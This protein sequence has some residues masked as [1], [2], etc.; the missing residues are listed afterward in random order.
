MLPIAKKPTPTKPFVAVIGAANMD[1][2]GKMT[3]TAVESDSNPG[4]VTTSSGGVARNIAE[5]LAY[6]GTHCELVTAV[7]A[8]EWGQQL[9]KHC[10][11]L[12]V[13]TSNTL[14]AEAQRTSSYLSMHDKQ[15]ELITAI[16]DMAVLDC[17]N[18]SV[19]A[20]RLETLQMA[21]CWVVDANL[22][23][24]SLAYLFEH[25]ENVPIWVDPVSTIKARR[26]LP[27]RS[28][29]HCITPNLQEAAILAGF[30]HV[31][32]NDAPKLA[33]ALHTSG[34]TQVMIT[35]GDRGA[36]VSDGN[37]AHWLDAKSSMVNNVTGCGDAAMAALVH[38]FVNGA[39]WLASGKL[40][41]S[42][43]ALTA[44][45]TQTNTSKLSSL[46]IKA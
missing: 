14:I 30:E 11:S 42:A 32:M 9:L 46:G 29:I 18:P 28:K 21:T 34:V 41:M 16:N 4:E 38:G 10:E 22:S 25:A 17:L 15:G 2:M 1:L 35:L 33:Q 39:D 31:T 44:S 37:N 20:L 7:G 26:L 3:G 19:L 23:E 13:G 45:S 27:Y 36:Y 5:N 12:G 6:L 24:A 43:A 8:D 40:A